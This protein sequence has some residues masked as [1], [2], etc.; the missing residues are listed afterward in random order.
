MEDS[1]LIAATLDGDRQA[2]LVLV[3]RYAP[4]AVAAA[5]SFARDIEV[6]EEVAASGLVLAY[7][8]L[9]AEGERCNMPALVVKSVRLAHRSWGMN[10]QAGKKLKA[11]SWMKALDE[12]KSSTARRERFMNSTRRVRDAVN[13]LPVPQRLAVNLR[14]MAG[15][16][17]RDVARALRTKPEA[18]SALLVKGSATLRKKLIDLEPRE[19]TS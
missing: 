7:G 1:G 4:L 12:S 18:V 2:F 6:A 11:V 8:R 19:R 15:M 9:G 3:G 5:Y 10:K 13:R 14:F 16:S 17:Y